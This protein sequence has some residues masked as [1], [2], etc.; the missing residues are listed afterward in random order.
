[1]QTLKVVIDIV[2]A[3]Y[4]AW[5]AVQFVPQYRRLKESIAKGDPVARIRVYR[6]ALTFEWI[7]ALLALAALGFDWN[8]LNPKFMG[9]AGPGFLQSLSQSDFV[10]GNVA[11]L[12]AG[13]VLGTVVLIFGRLRA[14]RRGAPTLQRPASKWSKILPDFSALVPVT[15]H[16]RLFWVGVAISAGICEE[17]VFRGWLLAMLHTQAGLTGTALI[18]A[19]AVAFGL[20]HAYQG[21]SGVLLT[22]FA[23]AF[24]CVLY[25]ETGS[26]LIPIL[27]H[28]F[29]DL[30][31]ALMPAPRM[32]KPLP[33]FA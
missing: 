22:A 23:G 32:E 26:L 24:F 19:G 15:T 11:G 18:V 21:I 14:N 33:S 17:L 5:E 20:A 3:C 16:E 27:L 31:F 12:A 28:A 9:F 6:R 29:I 4:I 7:S 25:I 10:R 8:Q 13:L 1:M 2:L 30:R